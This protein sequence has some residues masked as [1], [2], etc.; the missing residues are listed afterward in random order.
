MGTPLK[1]HTL[2]ARSSNTWAKGKNARNTSSDL[3]STTSQNDFIT[4]ITF[5]CD[6]STPLGTPV[7]PDVYIMIAVSELFGDDSDAVELL[8]V[9]SISEKGNSL[10]S[11]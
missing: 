7:D 8:P 2:S 11:A 5:V 9:W 3:I 6:K 1:R 10:T 4:E